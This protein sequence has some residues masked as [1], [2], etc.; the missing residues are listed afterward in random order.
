MRKYDPRNEPEITFLAETC[1]ASDVAKSVN[2]QLIGSNIPIF[3]V[4]AFGAQVL[5]SLSYQSIQP[6]ADKNDS[7]QERVVLCTE[8]IAS[9]ISASTKL[10]VN[11][12]REAFMRFLLKSKP[13]WKKTIK[14]KAERMGIESGYC[15]I[16]KTALIERDT[17]IGRG[18]IIEPFVVVK[19]GVIVGENTL[20]SSGS[21]LGAHG[22]ALYK[23][24]NKEVL[25]YAR[26]HFGTLIIGNGCE[27]GANT[28]ILR[29]MLG[30]TYIGCNTVLGN[31]VHIGH[32]CEIR[33]RV[34]MAARVT[35]CGH[36][37]IDSDVSI[38]AGA[39]IRDNV[40]IGRNASIGM[41]S[42]VISNVDVGKSVLGV[43]AKNKG[44]SFQ[45]GPS[46]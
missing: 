11:D 22:P 35:V 1:K 19:S 32:G 8:K 24:R 12:P 43:P 15:E 13:D 27:I 6:Q 2:A 40:D 34:W 18:A 17:V 28:V 26:I 42:V 37:F 25:S 21:I 33:K 3:G 31:M 44:M 9:S 16:D 23:T 14:Q 7:A 46:R 41:G 5:N 20:V 36:V 39:T 38:G 30:R 10:I 45:S 4:A 29:G